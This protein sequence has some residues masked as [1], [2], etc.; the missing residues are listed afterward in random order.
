MFV[1]SCS[2]LIY[3][4]F[5]SV[6]FKP[7]QTVSYMSEIKRNNFCSFYFLFRPQFS[8]SCSWRV[9]RCCPCKDVQHLWVPQ[10][11]LTNFMA[12]RIDWALLGQEE[13]EEGE[14]RLS[15]MGTSGD[16]QD[17]LPPRE[18]WECTILILVGSLCSVDPIKWISLWISKK[19]DRTG[20]VV[21]HE[22]VLKFHQFMW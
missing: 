6:I 13:A 12:P 11:T 18:N 20:G 21:F 14:V 17:I 4:Q 3:N 9:N 19:G 2:A 16:L 1:V 22:F 10:S 5:F 7:F 8:H 15:Q